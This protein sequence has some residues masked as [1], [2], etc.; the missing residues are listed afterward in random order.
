MV[1][2]C[3]QVR[4][5]RDLA[6][7]RESPGV[8]ARMFVF[9]VVCMAVGLAVLADAGVATWRLAA[10]VV[11]MLVASALHLALSR[12]ARRSGRI[13][14]TVL[15]NQLVS[16]AWLGCLFA[17]TGGLRS[18]FLPWV[19]GTIVLGAMMFG[20]TAQGALS[21]LVLFGVLAVVA[22]L[23]QDVTGPP[24]TGWHY[25]VVAVLVFLYALVLVRA[26]VAQ[27]ALASAEA[28]A[29]VDAQRE[30]RIAEAHAH[31]R[32]L[33]QIGARVADELRTPL[34]E[35]RELVAGLVTAGGSDKTRQRLEVVQSEIARM[36]TILREYLSYARPLED[37]DPRPV[38]LAELATASA[39]VV[40]GRAENARIALDV[41]ARPAPI[42][43]DPRRLREALMNLLSNAIDA[44]PTGGAVT[45]ETA[46]TDD[47]GGVVTIA[48]TGRGMSNEHVARLGTSYFTTRADGTGLGVV[49]VQGVVAQHGGRLD[50]ESQLGRGTRVTVRLPAQPPPRSG[51]VL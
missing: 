2:E 25:E 22:L 34:D 8:V 9:A 27:I 19:T 4:T 42:T 18:P 46:A 39:A 24:V 15:L 32:R 11:G 51:V 20:M 21:S 43:A 14:R 26:F 7:G 47:G 33:Q 50:Y 16:H 23:P 17:L 28:S 45:V 29:A 40:S 12:G 30:A 36:D 1:D 44:T 3:E 6:L 38:D 13:D 10:A 41:R 31:S 37:L 5:Q 48:D 49:L 35:I